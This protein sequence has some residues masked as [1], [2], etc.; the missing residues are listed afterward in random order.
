MR[1]PVNGKVNVKMTDLNTGKAHWD[2]TFD[3][4]N[5]YSFVLKYPK[6][7]NSQGVAG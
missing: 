6:N 3:Y 4:G 2:V 7:F 1:E 5:D